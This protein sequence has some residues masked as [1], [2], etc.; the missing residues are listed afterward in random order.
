MIETQ[1]GA[2]GR[3]KAGDVHAWN[4]YRGK[5]KRWRPDL[6]GEK[7]DGLALEGV[8][9]RDLSLNRASFREATLSRSEFHKTHYEEYPY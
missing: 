3:L 4:Q 5:D 1:S 2:L 7:F 9:L 8:N 6:E